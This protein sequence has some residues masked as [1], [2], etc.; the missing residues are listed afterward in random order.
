MGLLTFDDAALPPNLS[1]VAITPLMLAHDPK[2]RRVFRI[3]AWMARTVGRWRW[4]RRRIA[5]RL[6]R[7]PEMIA[8]PP[9]DANEIMEDQLSMAPVISARQLEAM[10]R[11]SLHVGHQRRV[12][13]VHGVDDQWVRDAEIIRRAA[14][15]LGLDRAHVHTL[16]SGGHT[17]QLPLANHPEWT[18]RNVDEIGR[19]IQSMMVTAHEQTRSPMDSATTATS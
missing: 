19:L 12:M 17:P 13:L 9:A 1:R 16:A 18:A 2:L 3:G 8:L 10:S 6:S 15:D 4:L 14:E 11:L 7:A 5:E